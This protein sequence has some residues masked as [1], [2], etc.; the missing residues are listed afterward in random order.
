ML[1]SVWSGTKWHQV[2]QWHQVAPSGTLSVSV[3]EYVK[4]HQ[5]APSGTLSVSVGEYVKWHQ[6]APSG[7]LSVGEYVKWHRVAPSG[8]LTVTIWR[9]VAL[10]GTKWHTDCHQVALSGTKWH[11]HCHQVGSKVWSR[12]RSIRGIGWIERALN[13]IFSILR[14]MN[15]PYLR[16]KWRWVA[17][18][19]TKWRTHCHQ[20]A[21]KSGPE[22]VLCERLGG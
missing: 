22:P 19:G 10:S 13:H 17:L 14:R 15:M 1:A 2:A 18:S 5:V 3:G 11:T 7:T 6:V 8:T 9:W 4:W 16:T 21:A 12:A 20:V